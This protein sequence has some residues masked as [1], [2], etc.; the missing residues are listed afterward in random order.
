MRLSAIAAAFAL[1]TLV[2]LA[3]RPA[4]AQTFPSHLKSCKKSREFERVN[5]EY[6][7]PVVGGGA[8][9]AQVVSQNY[10]CTN[11]DTRSPDTF[12]N[13]GM[14]NAAGKLVVP[15]AYAV[16]MPFSTTGAVVRAHRKA[17][18]SDRTMYLTYIAGKGE[19]RDRFEFQETRMLRPAHGCS[20]ERSDAWAD[21]LSAP[22][23]EMFF[24][25]DG[26][27]SHVTLFTAEGKARKLEYMGGDGLK[28]AV[29]RIGDVLLARWRDDQGVARSGILDLYGRQIAPVLA[30]SSLWL[31]PKTGLT[32]T[33]IDSCNMQSLDLF[34]EG[35]SLDFDPANTF[36]GPLLML[37]GRDGQPAVM[38]KG[39]IGMFPAYPRKNTSGYSDA[40][41]NVA[42]MWGVVFPKGNGFEFTLHLGAPSEALIAAETGPR[43]SDLGRSTMHGGLVGGHAVSDGQ[44]RFFRADTDIAV[45]DPSPDF[46]TAINSAVGVLNSEI[47][48]AQQAAAAAWAAQEASR[49]EAH[50]R[51]WETARA[52]GRLCDYRVDSTNTTAEVE[53]YMHACGP[54]HFP[55][56]AGLARAKGVPDHVIQAASEEEWRRL[57]NFA[58]S[59]VAWEEEARLI[60]MRNANQAAGASYIPGQWE[61]AIRNAGNAATDAINESSDNWLQQRRDQYV[62]DWQRSQRAY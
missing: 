22:F 11:K 46:E 25:V 5:A 52:A 12:Q 53:E 58:A 24:M 13:Y 42:S 18:T 2:P 28:P 30:N 9:K 55:G 33:S 35:P 8:G 27:K 3:G 37:V 36:F 32:T 45:G 10:D 20:G 34:V 43:Y 57:A 21:G 41:P 15:Y 47:A 38:P 49:A 59:R 14:K 23:G 44:W 26:G 17:P 50:K 6:L 29:R 56:L 39:A 54:S 62:A 51:H 31:T 48:Y 60:R 61:S 19:G 1:A 40:P 16:V 4:E 7:V